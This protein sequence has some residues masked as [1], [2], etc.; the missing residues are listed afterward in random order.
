MPDTD[1]VITECNIFDTEEVHHNCTVTVWS[2]SKTGAVSVGWEKNADTEA[3]F[4]CRVL[5]QLMDEPCL[6]GL[7]R[8]DQDPWCGEHCADAQNAEC[9]R[10]FFQ[11]MRERGYNGE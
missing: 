9:W 4:M 11:V 1:A 2:N 10:H 3:E 5:G 8:V 7:M 6:Y